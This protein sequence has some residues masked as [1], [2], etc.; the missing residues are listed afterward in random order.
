MPDVKR[1][2]VKPYVRFD[3]SRAR[4]QGAVEGHG[5]PVV[6]VAMNGDVED[7]LGQG[8][9]ICVEWWGVS[10]GED[11]LEGRGDAIAKIPF[12]GVWGE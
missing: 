8:G 6:V 12:G 9:R 5:S 11:V 7:A 10:F 1:L 4:R 3:G 2:V